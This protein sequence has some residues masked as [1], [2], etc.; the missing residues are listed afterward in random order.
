MKSDGCISCQSP[1]D[2]RGSRILI[3]GQQPI[4]QS[5]QCL[6]SQVGPSRF[7]KCD[8]PCKDLHPISRPTQ[9]PFCKGS[10]IKG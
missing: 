2:Y 5:N 10:F 4:T 3:W 9:H 6:T 7:S 1:F 8:K